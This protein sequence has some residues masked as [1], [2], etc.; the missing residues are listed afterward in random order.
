MSSRAVVIVS[1][2][3]ATMIVLAQLGAPAM[4]GGLRGT[5]TGG[6]PWFKGE[7]AGLLME[8]RSCW[9]TDVFVRTFGKALDPGSAN[10]ERRPPQL[11][12]LAEFKAGQDGVMRGYRL[13]T[14]GMPFRMLM[15]EVVIESEIDGTGQQQYDYRIVGGTDAQAARLNSPEYSW[16]IPVIPTDVIWLRLWGNAILWWTACAGAVCVL[17][18]ASRILRG[19]RRAREGRCRSCGYSLPEDAVRCPECGQ[20]TVRR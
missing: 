15:A 3:A 7:Y 2:I 5:N 17:S 12:R 11:G 18:G 9:G 20:Q 1:G 10:S 8:K 14:F 4:L 19:A 6:Y 13:V 16:L